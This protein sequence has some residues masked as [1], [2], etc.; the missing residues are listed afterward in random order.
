MMTY[1]YLKNTGTRSRWVDGVDMGELVFT[2]WVEPYE[3]FR[4]SMLRSLGCIIA[5]VTILPKAFEYMTFKDMD[6]EDKCKM[7][8]LNVG[9]GIWILD[10]INAY[11]YGSGTEQLITKAV[12]EWANQVNQRS[13][14]RKRCEENNDRN[15]LGVDYA[16]HNG[17]DFDEVH[18]AA[19]RGKGTLYDDDRLRARGLRNKSV[20]F[21]ETDDR[22]SMHPE[23]DYPGEIA[24]PASRPTGR[25]FDGEAVRTATRMHTRSAHHGSTGDRGRV[26]RGRDKE[27][28]HE[29]D[30]HKKEKDYDFCASDS[31]VEDIRDEETFDFC[32]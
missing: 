7:D 21:E 11:E 14:E 8:R 2:Q 22:D 29:E 10:L 20:S 23:M 30:S 17:R 16:R 6:N 32:E 27:D 3:W 26:G 1:F 9:L 24:T 19:T 12:K 18:V 5:N 28:F 25:N 13:I 4:R 15:H 31:D